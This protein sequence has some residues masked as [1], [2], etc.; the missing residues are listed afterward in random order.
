MSYVFMQSARHCWPTLTK[1]GVPRQIFVKILN[2]KPAQLQ[3]CSYMRR[4]GYDE[5]NRSFRDYANALQ[6]NQPCSSESLLYGLQHKMLPRSLA[7]SCVIPSD[8]AADQ[9]T[10]SSNYYSRATDYC[11]FDRNIHLCFLSLNQHYTWCGQLPK[12]GLHASNMK[13]NTHNKKCISAC[14]VPIY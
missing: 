13:F 3:R 10:A 2:I 5:A 14:A 8:G 1:F 7:T 9:G 4:D 12:Y 6:H 11:T